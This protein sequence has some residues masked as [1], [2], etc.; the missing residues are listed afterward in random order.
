MSG[1]NL[2]EGVTQKDIDRHA[3]GKPFDL[4]GGK[5]EGWYNSK[6]V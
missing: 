5:N 3:E 1:P 2:P 6:P 4:G